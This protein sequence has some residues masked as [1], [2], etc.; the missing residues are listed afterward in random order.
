M[1]LES[2][3]RLFRV[4]SQASSAR[5]RLPQFP[6]CKHPAVSREGSTGQQ[7]SP[8]GTSEQQRTIINYTQITVRDWTAGERKV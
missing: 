6:P 1:P 8:P 7:G 3:S 4:L 5:V 2:Q